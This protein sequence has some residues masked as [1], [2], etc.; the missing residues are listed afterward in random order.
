[1]MTTMTSVTGGASARTVPVNQ[2]RPGVCQEAMMVIMMMKKKM[3][4]MMM[5][6]DDRW[7]M[8]DG[9][10]DGNGYEHEEDHAKRR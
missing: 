8:R 1:M 3:K 7:Q 10:D 6:T 2:D 9:G 5:K 4:M